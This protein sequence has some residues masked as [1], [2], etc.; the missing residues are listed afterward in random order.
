[1]VNGTNGSNFYNVHFL[2]KNCS[3]TKKVN[4]MRDNKVIT[5]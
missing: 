1:M 3:A 4:I 2:W 5:L